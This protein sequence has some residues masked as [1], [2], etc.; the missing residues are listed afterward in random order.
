MHRQE[1]VECMECIIICII[2]QG[3]VWNNKK[4]DRLERW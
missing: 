1:G 4:K 2:T 3:G